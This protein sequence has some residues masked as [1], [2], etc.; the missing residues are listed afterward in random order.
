MSGLSGIGVFWAFSSFLSS[1]MLCVGFFMPYW[2][3]GHM[4]I[5]IPDKPALQF[6][7]QFGVFRRCNYP[8]IDDE[9]SLK[10]K[11][12]CGRYTHFSDIPST[13][14]QI[15]TLTIG[16]GCGLCLLVAF[17]AM[18]GL[19]VNSVVIPAVARTAGIIQ[20]CSGLLMAAGVGIYPNGWDSPE[21][22]QSCGYMSKSYILG[23]CSISWCFYLT[24]AG[25]G[26]TLMC[27]ALSFHAPKRKQFI[28]GHA[29]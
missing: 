9:G 25:I 29:L 6:S 20:M 22:Q 13:S 21:V 8:A 7:V 26:I 24:S 17:A 11:A 5:H 23:E 4:T 19:C 15:A 1:L 12:E 18:F 2:I 3:S 14:W 16:V 10:L 27:S 28:T